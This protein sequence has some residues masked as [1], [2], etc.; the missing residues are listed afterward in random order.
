MR[1]LFYV[2]NI[3]LII[4][5]LHTAF[6]VGNLWIALLGFVAVL[7]GVHAVLSI[8]NFNRRKQ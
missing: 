6:T 4:A 3:I 8:L 1:L 7:F 5:N 2:I